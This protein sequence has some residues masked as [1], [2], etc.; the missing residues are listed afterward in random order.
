MGLVIRST[1]PIGLNRL[2]CQRQTR[3]RRGRKADRFPKKDGNATIIGASASVVTVGLAEKAGCHISFVAY[4]KA[5]W[6]M[7]I[8]VTISMVY[9]LIAY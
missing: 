9:L 1:G 2:P 4:M 8:T 7:I 5:W 6:P 3:A